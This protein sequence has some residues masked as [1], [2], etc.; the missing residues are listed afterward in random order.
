MLVMK[1]LN[2]WLSLGLGLVMSACLVQAQDTPAK[3]TLRAG[4]ATSNISPPLGIDIVGNF[5]PIP[6]MHIHDELHARCLVLDDGETKIALVISDLLGLHRL[7]CLEARRLIQEQTGIPSENV[8]VAGT[9]THSAGSALGSLRYLQ[10]G[11]LNEYQLFVAKRIADGVK[12]ASNLLRPAEIA[13]GSIN[14]PE[15]VHNRRWFMNDA[16]P[17]PFGKIDKVK[18]NPPR[19]SDKLIEPAGPIDPE[20]C[21]FALRET[22]PTEGNGKM[23][24]LFGAY[25]LHYVG[26]VGSGH[27]SADYFAHFCKTLE[28]SQPKIEGIDP[29]PFVAILANGTSGDI[30]NIN[31][32]VAGERKK[33]YEQ[34]KYVAE[35]LAGKVQQ[36]IGNLKWS[37]EEP[38]KL[39]A[40]YQ[41]LLLDRKQIP[42]DLLKWAKETKANQPRVKGRF[43]I[44][45]I[46]A[47]RVLALEPLL[48]DKMHVPLQHLR[49]GDIGIGTF[50]TETFAETGLEFKKRSPVK[51]AFMVELAHGY[52]G[53]LPTPR[54]FELGGYETWPGT[55][56]LEPQASVKMLEALLEMAK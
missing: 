55:N 35:D 50:P 52:I 42:E 22:A 47:D 44:S 46:Y 4:A 37:G 8:L 31:F 7:V 56:H 9:H 30:N 32:R 34:I 33:P 40:R 11:P 23:I 2:S 51:H 45:Q 14:A 43:D 48:S 27:I 3:K 24:A 1:L 18:M 29:A 19:A 20:L 25:S 17:N 49:I 12:R 6:A 39:S 53:Y 28:Q 54:H 10:E 16:P 13:F 36:A 41:E 38:I 15:H 21:F 5:T 26:G